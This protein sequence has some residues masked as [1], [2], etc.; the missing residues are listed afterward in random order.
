MISL[1]LQFEQRLYFRPG[2]VGTVLT[3]S[4]KDKDTRR[5]TICGVLRHTLVIGSNFS[6]HDVCSGKNLR[7]YR[8]LGESIMRFAGLWQGRMAHNGTQG[9]MTVTHGHTRYKPGYEG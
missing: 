8:Q 4:T 5:G 9:R 2:Y 6:G 3:F 1:H 7:F